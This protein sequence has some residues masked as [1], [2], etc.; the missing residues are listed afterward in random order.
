[1]VEQDF[2]RT[3]GGDKFS[4][5]PLA[6]WEEIGELPRAST[7]RC[8]PVSASHN[9]GIAHALFPTLQ[10]SELTKRITKFSKLK[11]SSSFAD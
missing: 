3:N 5:S 4:P 1:M 9:E 10:R 8:N 7:D 6:V 2:G 11:K